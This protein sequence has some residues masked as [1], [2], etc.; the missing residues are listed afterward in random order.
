MHAD[1][2]LLQSQNH[3]VTAKCTRTVGSSG[4]TTIALR[5]NARGQLAPS[6]ARTIASRPNARGQLAPPE[7]EPLRYGQMHADS[8]LLWSQNH[9]VTAKCTRTVGSS[10]A[11]TAPQEASSKPSCLSRSLRSV[12]FIDRY[13]SVVR[14]CQEQI[15]I[16]TQD[17][18]LF[19]SEFDL[20]CSCYKHIALLS[21]ESS[22][23]CQ[24]AFIRRELN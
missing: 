18:S 23:A 12:I 22:R 10:G 11:R 17:I 4:A 16:W 1:S 14:L 6:R 9:C 2:W 13:L 5:P 8:W 24:Q 20:V 3:C 21:S 15:V 19:R 7:P